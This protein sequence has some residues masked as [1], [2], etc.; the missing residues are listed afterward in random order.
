MLLIIGTVLL[1]GR[2]HERIK[3][4]NNERDYV[5]EDPYIYT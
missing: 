5:T 3:S 1:A 2:K 4:I